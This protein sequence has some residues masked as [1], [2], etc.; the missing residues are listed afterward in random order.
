MRWCEA[1]TK[2]GTASEDEI[3]RFEDPVLLS[4][5]KPN[6]EVVQKRTYA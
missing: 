3:G 2:K 6:E 1:T 4:R 5:S